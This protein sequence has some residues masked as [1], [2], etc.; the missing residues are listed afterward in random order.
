[1]KN[2]KIPVI[3]FAILYLVIGLLNLIFGADVNSRFFYFDNLFVKFIGILLI[4]SSIGLFLRKEI[5]KRGI[6]IALIL[7]IIEIY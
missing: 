3:V 2:Y 4:T 1:M 5:A 6:I 7:S